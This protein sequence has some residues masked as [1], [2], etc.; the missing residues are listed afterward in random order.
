MRIKCF[1]VSIFFLVCWSS[2]KHDDDGS[3]LYLPRADDKQTQLIYLFS[4]LQT[5][6]I[7]YVGFSLCYNFNVDTVA[8]ENNFAA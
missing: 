7:K 6:M 2:L 1:I 4:A 8:S 5:C 3:C